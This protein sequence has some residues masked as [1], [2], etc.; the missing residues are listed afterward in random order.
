MNPELTIFNS[1]FSGPALPI[2]GAGTTL[3]CVCYALALY[4]DA[5]RAGLGGKSDRAAIHDRLAWAI[6]CLGAYT[7]IM[8]SVWAFFQSTAASVYPRSALG[9][10]GTLMEA[11][12]RRFQEYSF[13]NFS[14]A[15]AMKD[16]F[17]VATSLV[18]FVSALL[19]YWSTQ[20]F[21]VVAYNCWFAL[22][23]LLIGLSVYPGMSTLRTWLMGTFEISAWSLIQAIVFKTIEG[24]LTYYLQ[25]AAAMP[26]LSLD[27]LD[28]FS[29]LALLAVLPVVVPTIAA[30][31]FGAGIGAAF[32]S[33]QMPSISPMAFAAA[34]GGYVGGKFGSS[35][36][37]P[38][39]A[40]HG[41]SAVNAQRSKRSGD[42]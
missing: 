31:L 3:A 4:A 37:E 29:Q 5:Q 20:T 16:G 22:G 27:F 39:A 24:T 9:A 28:V 18:A 1:V 36:S 41:P 23:P 6:L 38:S 25:R 26:L 32:A 21:Q 8:G 14:V 40:G 11:A 35:K 2:Y 19:G 10:I 7:W 33:A 34:V 17:I 15:S 13:S 42:V 12:L 30:R